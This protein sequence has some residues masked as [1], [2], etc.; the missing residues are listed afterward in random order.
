MSPP[1]TRKVPSMNASP[2]AR[3]GL[4]AMARAAF[5]SV[6]SAVSSGVP[7]PAVSSRPS[8]RRTRTARVRKV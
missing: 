7:G 4:A 1:S 5:M 6:I 8:G 2:R 3:S